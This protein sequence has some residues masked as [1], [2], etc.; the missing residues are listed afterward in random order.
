MRRLDP[1][2][3]TGTTMT[4][5]ARADFPL[6]ASKRQPKSWTIYQ[7]L[8]RRILLGQLSADDTLTE[9]AL[10]QEFSC[11]QGTVREAL[12]KLEQGGLV[13]R[14]GYEGTFITKTTEAE[15]IVMVQLRIS[16]EC[17]GVERAVR[18][19]SNDQLKALRKLTDL[20]NE[21]SAQQDIFACSEADRAFHMT[22]FDIADMPMLQPTLKRT[23][24]HLHRYMISRQQ[25]NV[26]LS[27]HRLASHA[28]IL[29]A[30]EARDA[31]SA[32]SLSMRHISMSLIRHMPE[33]HDKVFGDVGRRELMTQLS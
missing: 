28:Q 31:V 6:I 24:I 1:Q 16:L 27:E 12:L 14:R 21:S 30:F 19:A 11:S 20:Y 7:S 8:M 32:K 15:A 26:V 17:A 9:Q 5:V 22:I 10:A 25:G 3:G 23:L 4:I 18:S 2:G 13:D 29:E 33:I